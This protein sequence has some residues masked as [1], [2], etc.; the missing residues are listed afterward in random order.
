MQCNLTSKQNAGEGMGRTGVVADDIIGCGLR[1]AM[2]A[3][4]LKSVSAPT[5]I[6]DWQQSVAYALG[7]D[8]VQK[9]GRDMGIFFFFSLVWFGFS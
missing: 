3:G 1:L 9:G 6:S 7:K 5:A 4:Q 2:L 8:C